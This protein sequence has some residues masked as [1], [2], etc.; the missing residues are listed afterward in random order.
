MGAIHLDLHGFFT[1]TFLACVWR[2]IGRMNGPGPATSTSNHEKSFC[3][4]F[5]YKYG[6]KAIRLVASF[7]VL[8]LPC[9]LV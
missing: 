6:I 2:S 8:A 4:I 7:A 9:Y 1:R 3:N 5:T